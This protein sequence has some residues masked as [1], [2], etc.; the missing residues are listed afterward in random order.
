MC[1]VFFQEILRKLIKLDRWVDVSRLKLTQWRL[2]ESDT[3]SSPIRSTLSHRPVAYFF[4]SLFSN[5]IRTEDANSHHIVFRK[6]LL[7]Y[8]LWTSLSAPRIMRFDYGKIKTCILL[9]RVL[10]RF[11]VQFCS[12]GLHV[13][14]SK[15]AAHFSP[16]CA[17]Q[18]FQKE[19]RVG[20]FQPIIGGL[21]F[22]TLLPLWVPVTVMCDMQKNIC[23]ELAALLLYHR[24]KH[25]KKLQLP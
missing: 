6:Y 2:R 4:C 11:D 15:G 25:C 23:I 21:T 14:P 18:K 24:K 8:S 7:N 22:P 10:T 19:G 9:Y 1:D 17:D 16:I 3:P 12:S 20:T 13:E 5:R